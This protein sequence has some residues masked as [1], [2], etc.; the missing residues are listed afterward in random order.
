M[1]PVG[2]LRGGVAAPS[3][4]S[5]L[6]PS[7]TKLSRQVLTA[8]AAQRDLTY[9]VDTVG[10]LEPER[11]TSIAP[12]VSGVVDEVL[13][14]EGDLVDADTVLV[15]INQ[16]RYES[17]EKLARANVGQA[18]AKVAL[19]QDQADRARQLGERQAVSQ[20][21]ARRRM[22]ELQVV[23]AEFA[24]AQASL[25]MAEHD[26]A[27]SRVRPP[28]AGQI[29]ARRVASGD[30]VKEE[31][32]VATIADLSKLR[33]TTWVP[34]MAAARVKLGDTLEFELPAVPGRKFPARIFFLSTVADPQSH[35]FE[36][37]AEIPE[38]DPDM[39]P[40]LFARVQ[41]ATEQHTGAVVVPEESVRAGEQGFVVYVAESSD[42]RDGKASGVARVRPVQLGFRRPGFVEVL[43]GITA[44]DRVV[45]RGSESLEDGT[46]IEYPVETKASATADADADAAADG[47]T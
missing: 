15:R 29:N 40:G 26:L 5:D 10:S 23:R 16:E 6:P 21:E 24:A 38:P 32:V 36:C 27:N 20:E 4:G 31:T 37:K 41:I 17:A 8:Q 13:F 2:C 1:I 30:Y 45:T 12:G 9:T 33:L 3:G 14:H 39:K 25:A 11:Q 28:Y 19:A 42:A 47:K 34:E 35:M 44:E 46:P 22:L 43:A 18:E 7:K